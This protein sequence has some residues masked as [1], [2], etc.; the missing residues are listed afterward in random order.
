MHNHVNDMQKFCGE[1]NLQQGYMCV[2]FFK[3]LCIYVF[4]H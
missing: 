3:V 1:S 2:I 4:Y